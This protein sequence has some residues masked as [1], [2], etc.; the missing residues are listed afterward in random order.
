MKSAEQWV[1][2]TSQSGAF[3]IYE[4]SFETGEDFVRAIQDDAIGSHTKKMK[5]EWLQSGLLSYSGHFP[6][7]FYGKLGRKYYD[8]IKKAASGA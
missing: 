7:D 2:D 1:S 3:D 5:D 4:A 8:A 6:N